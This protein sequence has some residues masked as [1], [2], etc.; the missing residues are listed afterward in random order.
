M[1]KTSAFIVITSN[2]WYHVVFTY[3]GKRVTLYGDD[4]QENYEDVDEVKEAVS[5]YAVSFG[6]FMDEYPHSQLNGY[7]DEVVFFD[8]ALSRDDASRIY[9][10]QKQCYATQAYNQFQIVT[11]IVAY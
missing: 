11:L 8:F 10:E 9:N 4:N 3:D 5:Q 6:G 7:L 2:R 1:T